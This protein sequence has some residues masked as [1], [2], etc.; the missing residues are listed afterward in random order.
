MPQLRIGSRGSKLALWQ[1]EHVA[2]GLRRLHPGGE[3][4]I[5]V[6]KTTAD[7]RPDVPLSAI[8]DKSLFIKEI[9][10]ALS[11]GSIDAG[12]HSLK[13]VPSRLGQQFCL[14]AVLAREDPRDV[15]LCS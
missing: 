5:V 8:G 14:A 9:E 12:V 1:A 7:K 6:I 11:D 2:A 13:D 4:D 10:V 3:V 15:L